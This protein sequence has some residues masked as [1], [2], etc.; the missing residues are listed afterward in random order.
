MTTRYGTFTTQAYGGAG[1]T[2]LQCVRCTYSGAAVSG[3]TIVFGDTTIGDAQNPFDYQ[4]TLPQGAD[5]IDAILRVTDASTS[6]TMEAGYAAADGAAGTT[7]SVA[8]VDATYFLS[9]TAVAATGI[10][11]ADGPATVVKLQRPTNP[12]VTITSG[13]VGAE[14]VIELDVFYYYHGNE[15]ANT[16]E[17][18]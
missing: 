12:T 6:V 16:V 2:G 4:K 13:G 9:A 5:P 1:Q 7:N 15:G 18:A 11:R 17:D 3:D 8:D 14:A 10:K